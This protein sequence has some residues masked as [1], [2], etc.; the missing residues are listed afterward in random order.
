MNNSE[1]NNIIKVNNTIIPPIVNQQNENGLYLYLFILVCTII[2]IIKIFSDNNS[3]ITDLNQ[4]LKICNTKISILDNYYNYSNNIDFISRNYK[5]NKN[6]ET[7]IIEIFIY[8]YNKFHH[9]TVQCYI[10][11]N[12][13]Y[14]CSN[15]FF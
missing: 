1:K 11:I 2:Y 14:K 15:F 13:I 8:I 3:L 4:D 12:I 5:I 6:P 9:H 10:P 7:N